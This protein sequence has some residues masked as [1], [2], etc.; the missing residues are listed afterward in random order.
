MWGGEIDINPLPL[1]LE[2]AFVNF[3]ENRGGGYPHAATSFA[4]SAASAFGS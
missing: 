2:F 1:L 4:W 3:F